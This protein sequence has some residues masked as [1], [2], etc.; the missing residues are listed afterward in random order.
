MFGATQVSKAQFLDKARQAREE[1]KGIKDKER[2]VIKI[3]ALTRRFL[4]RCRLQK[5]IR[6][7]VDEFLETTQKSSVKPYALSIFRIARKML[8]VFQMSP[9]KGRFE[10]LCRC[11]LNS[12]ENE[13]EPKVWFVSLAISKDLTLL[14]IKQIKD[15]LWYCCEFLKMLK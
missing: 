11:I 2:A 7:E 3:Q 6:Q 4:C 5:E 14:W 13:N 15:I 8:V 1:R 12:M 9:D 10:K